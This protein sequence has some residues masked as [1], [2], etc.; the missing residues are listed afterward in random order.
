MEKS[1]LYSN[2]FTFFYFLFLWFCTT[3]TSAQNYTTKG[4]HFWASFGPNEITN[5]GALKVYIS[6]DVAASG[7]ISIP[8]KTFNKTFTVA[9][10]STTEIDLPFNQAIADV[11]ETV[12]QSGILIE[13]DTL[14]S[15]YIL[16]YYQHTA[17][18]AIVFPTPTLGTSYLS[19]AYESLGGFGLPSQIYVVATENNT[20]IAII[21]KVTTLAGKPADTPFNIVLNKGET[22]L[23]QADG[24]L[25]GTRI[26]CKDPN[27]NCK[28]F[29][30]FSGAKCTNVGGCAACDHLLEQMPPITTWGYDFVTV[31]YKTR[32]DDE[33]RIM[34]AR[35]T[36]QVSIDGGPPINMNA[37]QYLLFTTWGEPHYIN[38]T[39]PL[40][41]AQYSK[42]QGC[43]N[44]SADPFFIMVSPVQQ[45]LSQIS[46]NAFNATV[47][48]NY[49]LNVVCP[50]AYAN[51]IMLDGVA[52][53][54][55]FT[56]V[57]GN[58]KFAA[59]QIDITQGN[60]TL[61]GCDFIAYV[62]GYGDYE[63][64]GYVAGANLQPS[65]G[66]DLVAGSDTLNYKDF[67]KKLCANQ[68][69]FFLA[70]YDPAILYYNW[71]F[72][73]G[74][75]GVGQSTLHSYSKPG[76]YVASL[77]TEAKN[78]CEPDTLFVNI[79]IVD[80][81]DFDIDSICV[82]QSITLTAL[83]ADSYLW[84]TG[85]T[86][87]SITATPTQSTD[88][89]CQLTG[90]P[91]CVSTFTVS[92]MAFPT[93]I[94][95][96][97]LSKNNICANEP[98]TITF[99][100]DAGLNP[101]VEWNFDGGTIISGNGLGPYQIEWATT[102]NKTVSLNITNDVN[103]NNSLSLPLT[104]N[105]SPVAT[106]NLSDTTLCFA[107]IVT[108]SYGGTIEPTHTYNWNFDG[109][110]VQTGNGA[111]PYNVFWPSAGNYTISLQIVDATGCKSNIAQQAVLVQTISVLAS[112][113]TLI[114]LGNSIEIVATT[115]TDPSGNAV[116]LTW[117]P[118]QTLT[119]NDCPTPTAN[120]T[121]TTTYSVTATDSFG[122]KASDEIIVAVGS[123]PPILIMPTAFS[124][125]NISVLYDV[126]DFQHESPIRSTK[127]ELSKMFNRS[128]SAAILYSTC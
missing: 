94:P 78:S 79:K 20:E 77:T 106:I 108:I 19:L 97:T 33:V 35:D 29:A 5:N 91:K 67:D 56:P 127:V 65:I 9:A 81:E 68:P 18:A 28:P 42:G 126:A 3:A 26:E 70:K 47:I 40:A 82:G 95:T 10:N 113:D 120:P 104:V 112:K 87:K 51:K 15:A 98:I 1:L 14:V 49:Y 124:P 69:I 86:T 75:M 110:T 99:T 31:P 83:E 73:D 101:L 38:G 111:G 114:E 66:F 44:A 45:S 52:Q 2:I 37:G 16:N 53:T 54:A 13:T 102:G 30:V 6:S 46:F 11:N 122:C 71:D 125:N 118:A 121:Q 116:T 58:P 57:A 80:Y 115:T 41:V 12:T 59:A 27:N 7:T 100:G 21:P 36:T 88:Y 85:E 92:V 72:G 84:S 8:L 105:P 93:P 96:F 24:D 103:C 48:D 109:G 34:A 39:K 63:S 17:D 4:K 43:D 89:T 76:N 64:F 123:P 61:E 22:Y 119:C 90:H 32:K 128:T 74:N 25:T 62:Y 23:L 60:H 50:A 117:Q 55:N 107:D